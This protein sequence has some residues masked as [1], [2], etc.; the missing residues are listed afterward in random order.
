MA[1]GYEWG[2]H[3]LAMR[4]LVALLFLAPALLAGCLG[5]GSEEATNADVLATFYPL[6]FLAERIGG[7]NVT[8]ATLV[9]PGVEP[10]D[11]EPSPRDL[12]RY[13]QAKVV[14]AQG[15]GFEPWLDGVRSQLTHDPT[16]IMTLGIP[17]LE[18]GHDHDDHAD[19]LHEDEH[20]DETHDDDVHAE[21]DHANEVHEDVHVNETHDDA[22]ETHDDADDHEADD[23]HGHE[24][25]DPHTW[26]DPLTFAQQAR[27]VERALANAFPEHADAF[28][29]RRVALVADL[30]ALHEEFKAGLKTCERRFIIANHDAYGYMAERY[31]FQVRS[32]HGL[33]PSAEP[34]PRTIAML[35]D[36]AREHN[37][38][39]IYFEE[40]A[41][42]RVAQIIA[43]ETGAQTRVLSPIEGLTPEARNA[44]ADYFSLMREN[45][46][47]LREGMGCV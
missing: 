6:A 45:L 31:A 12:V 30:Q 28:R 41:S 10:H 47:N 1:K 18:G 14:L 25:Y 43:R 33:S 29:E 27:L 16:A 23:D 19:E 17:L 35:I 38:P 8:V 4:S 42:D 11:W 21:D 3:R 15:A 20:A 7:D 2:V 46:A 37:V 5:T 44:G 36:E 34:D 22:N 24:G 9:P 13:A 39:I 40:L 32:I 26:L